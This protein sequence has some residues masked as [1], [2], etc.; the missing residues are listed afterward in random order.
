LEALQRGEPPATK[1]AGDS[2]FETEI[3]SFLQGGKKIQAIKLYREKTGVG[4]K[5]AKDFIEALAADRRIATAPRSGCMGVVLLLIAVPLAAVVLGGQRASNPAPAAT[6]ADALAVIKSRQFVDLTHAFEPGIPHWPGFPDEKRETLYGYDGGTMGKGFFAQQFTHV[7]QWGTHCDPPA[8]FVK[9]KRTIDQIDPKEMILPLV[10][11]DVHQQAAKN[12]DYTISMDDVRNWERRQ[13][14]IPVGA[15][16]AMRTDWSK[17]WPDA[18]A[19]RNEDAKGVAHYPGWS[20]EVL[21]YLYE[22]R[23]ITASGHETPDTDP[24]IATS[25]GDYSLETYILGTDHYQIELLANLD[26]VPEARAI[27]VVTFPKPKGGS[28]F[29]ARVFAIVP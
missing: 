19:M 13:G 17:R 25:K 15:L 9:G 10:V 2:S 4:L 12:P 6:L 5:E 27:V 18:K 14:P 1:Q 26:K 29:P 8:H 7:G 3:I 22:E 21:K 16:V 24:G 11:L 20:K 23:K 28:G